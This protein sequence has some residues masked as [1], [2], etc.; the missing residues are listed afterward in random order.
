MV[1]SVALLGLGLGYLL[2]GST[3]HKQPLSQRRDQ[4]P[5]KVKVFFLFKK[6]KL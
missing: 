6:R 1:I 4:R 5:R 3:F 2:Y